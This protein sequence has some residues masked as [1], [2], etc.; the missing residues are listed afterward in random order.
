[1]FSGLFQL[2]FQGIVGA[3]NEG[4]IALD[5][6]RME[7]SGDDST[8]P[9]QEMHV[10]LPNNPGSDLGNLGVDAGGMNHVQVNNEQ[11]LRSEAPLACV[12]RMRWQP[13]VEHRRSTTIHSPHYHHSNNNISNA[14]TSDCIK[15]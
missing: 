6:I 7:G 2:T 14:I 15:Q 9:L 12:T 10:D 11:P 5:D 1:M 3:G 13:S 4:D 8:E